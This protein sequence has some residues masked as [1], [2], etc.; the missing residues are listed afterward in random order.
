MHAFSR[1]LSP[2]VL[3]VLV[4]AC[5][6]GITYVEQTEQYFAL[7]DGRTLT[8]EATGGLAE[9]H[10]YTLRDDEERIFDRVVRRS[11]FIDDDTTLSFQ[12]TDRA[13]QI[14][15]MHDC[16]TLCGEL[17]EPIEIAERPLDPGASK[18]TDVTVEVTR[19]G[20]S[21]GTRT[22]S[23]VFQ[24]GEEEEI[25]VPH[26]TFTAHTIVWS[27]TVDDVASS[28]SLVFAPEEGFIVVESFAG[29]RYELASVD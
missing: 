9:T 8:F 6:P 15:R 14:V 10:E 25:T 11:G 18:T 1:L 27:R 3:V 24:V 23:H 19:N 4:S 26:G 17:S 22:E 28:A 7:V 13:L 5:G 12:P 20:V 16:L 2:L 21:E 29:V